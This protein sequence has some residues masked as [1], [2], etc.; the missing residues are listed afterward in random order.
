MMQN[1]TVYKTQNKKMKSFNYLKLHYLGR[2]LQSP[3]RQLFTIETV[4]TVDSELRGIGLEAGLVVACS[5]TH[6]SSNRLYFLNFRYRV[7]RLTPNT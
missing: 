2:S 5:V 1:E 6:F 3:R 4:A 7:T